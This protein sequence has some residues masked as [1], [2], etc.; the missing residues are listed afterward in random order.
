MKNRRDNGKNSLNEIQRFQD[1][2]GY[3]FPKIYIDLARDHDALR[4][5]K[6]Y[7]YKI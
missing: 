5:E 6:N 3:F 7:A 2:L 1:E 4:F